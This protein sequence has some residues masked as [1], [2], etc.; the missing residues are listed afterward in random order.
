MSNLV[1][2]TDHVVSDHVVV[3]D[4]LKALSDTTV[5]RSAVDQKDI[6][7]ILEIRKMATFL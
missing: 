5:R 2:I 6:K 7:T 4:L 1:K 3:S